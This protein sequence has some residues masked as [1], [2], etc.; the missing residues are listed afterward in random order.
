MIG[1]LKA[2]NGCYRC[3]QVKGMRQGLVLHSLMSSICG[4]SCCVMYFNMHT[5]L[6]LQ[7]QGPCIRGDPNALNLC[8][9]LARLDIPRAHAIQGSMLQGATRAPDI[10]P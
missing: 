7:Q 3:Q 5:G 4:T 6:D 9:D 8:A 10:L 1:L 2:F